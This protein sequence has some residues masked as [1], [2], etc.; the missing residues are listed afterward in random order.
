MIRVCIVEDVEGIRSRL[1]EQINQTIDMKCSSNYASGEEALPG[2]LLTKPD[3]VIMDIRLDEGGLGD[4]MN[5]IQCMFRVRARNSSIR[6]L[7]FTV[8]EED[9]QVF[10]ALKAGADGYILKKDA[11]S[12]IIDAIREIQTG[13]APMS[14]SIAKKVMNSFRKNEKQNRL[15]EKLSPRQHEILEQL[16]KGYFYKEIAQSLNITQGTLKQHIHQIYK[17]LQVNNR[18]EAINKYLDRD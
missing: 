6:F 10:E 5:G 2:I 15:I 4:R 1:C 9:D 14:R 18:T 8:F 13:G 17:K 11:G 7:M 3:V 12:K 16:S